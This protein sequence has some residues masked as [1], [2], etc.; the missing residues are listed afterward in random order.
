MPR[1][2]IKNSDYWLTGRPFRKPYPKPWAVCLIWPDTH[3]Y[4]EFTTW[5]E[6]VAF[7]VAATE[8]D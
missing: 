1:A 5:P 7:A 2:F 3:R 8:E 4:F 6:A